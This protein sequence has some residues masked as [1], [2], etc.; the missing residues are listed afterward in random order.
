MDRFDAMRV[1][2]R[3]VERRSFTRAADDLGLPRSSVTDAVKGLEAR[4]GVR[5]LQRST[6]HVSPTLDGE[7][8]YRRC[9]NLISDLEDAEAGFTGA[10]PSGLVRID[11]HGTQARHFLLPGLPRFLDAYPDIHLH[12]GEAHQALDMV[13]E[14]F[15]CMLRAGELTVDS[16][17]IRRRL[18]TLER[19]TFAS[20]AY[21]S[22]FG[23]PES[24]DALEADGHRMVGF[25]APDAPEVAPFNFLIDGK[26][27]RLSLPSFVTVTGPETNVAS[28]CMG[29][30]LIQIPRYRAAAEL[31]SGKLVEVLP[32]FP[33]PTLPVHVLY[34]HTR[35][36]SPRLRVVID[37]MAEQ[38]RSMVTP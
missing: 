1:F 31:A 26:S 37:W 29:L 25:Y 17:L 9:L 30:G 32:Q 12:I 3:I 28:A 15:D 8:Y 27:R 21:I 14:G 35:Q 23:M 4:L 2:I 20:P 33:P 36:L 10:K 11:V 13:R 6:R 18:A 38:F 19:G 24:V 5:L 22:R 7:A 16:A 34:S